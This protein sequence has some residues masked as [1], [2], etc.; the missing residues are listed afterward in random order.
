LN[1][2]TIGTVLGL[3]LVLIALVLGGIELFNVYDFAPAMGGRHLYVYGAFGVIGLIGLILAFWA[4]MKK[5]T[6]IAAKQ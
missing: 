5:E 1:S 3:L 4:L 2:K 6:P